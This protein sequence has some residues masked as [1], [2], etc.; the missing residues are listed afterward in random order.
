MSDNHKQWRVLC[1]TQAQ[2]TASRCRLT[3]PHGRVTVHIRAVRSP[4]TGCQVKS[5]PRDRFS[6]Y[7]KWL[8]TFRTTLVGL[9]LSFCEWYFVMNQIILFLYC[10]ILDIVMY[11]KTQ[12]KGWV[13]VDRKWWRIPGFDPKSINMGVLV[14]KV[15]VEQQF[16]EKLYFPLPVS[17][18]HL[19]PTLISTLCFIF[20]IESFV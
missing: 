2:S 20:R 18:Y 11:L 12:A 14:K 17:F 3:T 7:W 8:N 9:F 16:F 6:R 1:S 4:L 5:R 19:L 15:S 10:I 13:A